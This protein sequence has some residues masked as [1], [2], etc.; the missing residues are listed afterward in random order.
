MV[1]ETTFNG[2]RGALHRTLWFC[3]AFAEPSGQR[4]SGP[5]IIYLPF[6]SAK[7]HFRTPLCGWKHRSPDHMTPCTTHVTATRKAPKA[8]RVSRKLSF[9]GA[10]AKWPKKDV[11]AA[12][13]DT[14]AG[15]LNVNVEEGRDAA[16]CALLDVLHHGWRL[17]NYPLLLL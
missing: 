1:F 14:A 6:E 15:I 7:F 10:R 13:S 8:E 3:S 5:N 16:R 2:Q 12:H 4:P 11:G 9:R 17:R